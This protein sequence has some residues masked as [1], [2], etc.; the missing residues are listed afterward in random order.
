MQS[1]Q[2]K[3]SQSG[4]EHGYSFSD[5]KIENDHRTSLRFLEM[6]NRHTAMKP[7]LN[8]FI[9]E[10]QKITGCEAIGVRILDENG[11]I[12]Y[13]AYIGFS[14]Q[15]YEQE[16]PLSIECDHCMCVNVVKG[17]TDPNLPIY[18]RGGSFHTN[19]TT[20]YLS[21][22][23]EAERK[24]TRNACNCFGYESVALIP[25]RIGDRILG[26]IHIAD[27]RENMI[28]P[29]TVELFEWNVQQ[30]ALAVERIKAELTSEEN[31]E[32]FK[33]LADTL[34]EGMV[35]RLLHR[36][37]GS[38]SFTYASEGCRRLFHLSPEEIA[39]DANVLYD[40]IAPEFL[41]SEIIAEKES[42]ENLKIF[43]FEMP[44]TLQNG[45]TRWIR[46]HSKPSRLADGTLI[47]DGVCLDVSRHR[48]MEEALR[49]A[50]DEL[51]VQVQERTK[52]LSETNKNLRHEIEERKQAEKA[53][54]LSKAFSQTVLMSLRDHIAVLDRQGNI[55]EVN[56]S[57]KQFA[58]ENNCQNLARIGSGVNY[59]EVCRNSSNRFDGA[60]QA[61]LEGIRSVLNGDRDRFEMEYPC[62]S[63]MEK[64][65]FHMVGI[66]FKRQEGG[67]IVAHTDTTVRKTAEVKLR[68]AYSEIE[69]LKNQLQ[70]DQTYL[71]E[72]IK[73]AHNYENIIGNSE[74]LTYVLFRTEQIAPTDTTVLILGET[75]T[76]KEL[77]ARAIHN[78]SPRKDRP[79]IKVDCASLP[80]HLIESELFGHEKG[81]FTGADKRRV[82]R[83]E[84]ANGAT[85][86]LDEIGDLPLEL[87]PKLLR[88]LQDGEFE[89]LGSS[90]TRRTEVRVIAATNRNIEEDVENKKFRMDLLYR[91]SVYTI[92]IP[93]LRDRVDDIGILVNYMVGKFERKQGKR[94]RS[95]PT[96]TLA[97]LQN[98]SW[99]G[100]VR[101]LE[102]VI[103]RAV[104]N[105]E[106]DTL[107]LADDLPASRSGNA[108]S[109]DLPIKSLEEVER[110]H[111]LLS[112]RKTNWKIQGESGAAALLE[113]NSSTLRGRMRKLGIHRPPYRT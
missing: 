64:R 38:R 80:A 54:R 88:V 50:R 65:W 85:I 57:W 82:G 104:I 56:D 24:Q 14:N 49:N 70:E 93:P 40:M 66:P 91:L 90:Q 44:M 20:H 72:E 8:E 22:L 46:W 48:Q 100:N 99:P 79:L 35:Y 17:T 59:L 106:G 32:R 98:Y 23:N 25:I 109:P 39:N 94:I 113:I 29:Q 78:A 34:P 60:A 62:D 89:R 16:S 10:I 6:A 61:A 19:G 33:H 83:F 51:E 105:T 84:L 31:Q 53:L 43:D 63:P 87:Q 76:G 28:S 47:W 74:K 4:V 30:L 42:M 2:N 1:P 86:F 5:N 11:N 73:L 97:N 3:K 26:L 67:V 36:P 111:I 12:P 68:E 75:G 21:T 69:Q 102:N 15:F 13:Q 71:R 107:Q 81:A 9:Y 52:D 55:L 103:Q 37:D 18:T 95:V 96:E 27:S 112:L 92:T 110:E 45:D 77:I 58:R 101:E 41:E 108:E 7:L